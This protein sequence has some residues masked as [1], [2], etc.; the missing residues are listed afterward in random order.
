MHLYSCI[1]L[2]WILVLIFVLRRKLSIR[3]REMED[4]L[5]EL[6][7]KVPGLEK[8]KARLTAENSELTDELER[9]TNF[10]SL[11]RF[12]AIYNASYLNLIRYFLQTFTFQYL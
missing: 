8:A 10:A 12:F 9:V 11:F 4:A 3:V 1:H 5:T 2:T 7:G 6:Q